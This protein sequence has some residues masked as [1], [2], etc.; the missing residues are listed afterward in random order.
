MKNS[1]VKVSFAASLLVSSAFAQSQIVNQ[2]SSDIT[3]LKAFNTNVPLGSYGNEL[4]FQNCEVSN[5]NGNFADLDCT[6]E[7]KNIVANKAPNVVAPLI[8]TLKFGSAFLNSNT[9]TYE[10]SQYFCKVL[11]IHTISKKGIADNSTG[12]GF[13]KDGQF[14]KVPKSELV[15]I[16]EATLKDGNIGEIH[17]FIGTG[18]CWRGSASSSSNAS[19]SFKPFVEFAGDNNVAYRNWDVAQN[20]YI[21]GRVNGNWVESFDRTQELTK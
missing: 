7:I 10:V 15:K 17:K 4:N 18:F 16:G 20:N 19:Y 14:V 5:Q 13:F 21:V 9:Q 3:I 12:I 6:N 1:F 8:E 2:V 11:E